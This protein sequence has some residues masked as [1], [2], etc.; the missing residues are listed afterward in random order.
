MYFLFSDDEDESAKM[1]V[2]TKEDA[3]KEL[4]RCNLPWRYSCYYDDEHPK[5]SY[6][7]DELFA[8]KIEIGKEINTLNNRISTQDASSDELFRMAGSDTELIRIVESY[9]F[10][11]SQDARD[12]LGIH[13]ARRAYTVRQEKICQILNERQRVTNHQDRLVSIHQIM[14]ELDEKEGKITRKNISI[15]D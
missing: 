14:E 5:P 8:L 12:V 10:R 7:V 6:K 4:I 1:V 9:L 13:S 2:N 15:H 11:K 3:Y